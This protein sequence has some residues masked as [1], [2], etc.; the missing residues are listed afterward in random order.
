[1]SAPTVSLLARE[2]RVHAHARHASEHVCQGLPSRA[3][4][5]GFQDLTVLLLRTAVALGG[6][7]F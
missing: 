4:Q 7:L 2:I 5:S 3:L 6:S 1:M